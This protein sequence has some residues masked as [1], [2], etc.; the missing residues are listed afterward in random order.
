MEFNE[1]QL[2]KVNQE[3]PTSLF[4]PQGHRLLWLE[5][6]KKKTD[7][8]F[9]KIDRLKTEL[10]QPNLTDQKKNKLEKQIQTTQNKIE[11]LTQINQKEFFGSRFK[12]Y[13]F[14]KSRKGRK[15]YMDGLDLKSF[16]FIHKILGG[17]NIS[18][19]LAP[20]FMIEQ[21]LEKESYRKDTLLGNSKT[22]V[23]KQSDDVISGL[24][25]EFLSQ[26]TIPNK[27]SQSREAVHFFISDFHNLFDANQ[28]SAERMMSA[29]A[30]EILLTQFFAHYLKLAEDQMTSGDSISYRTKIKIYS[31]IGKI[32]NSA[33]QF[34]DFLMAAA[35]AVNPDKVNFYK[36]E[37]IEK[38]FAFLNYFDQIGQIIKQDLS[39]QEALLQI[40]QAEEKVK[41]FSI[42]REK[43]SKINFIPF[44]KSK[45][46]CYEMTRKY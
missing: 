40:N 15:A 42:T 17:R 22:P 45:G 7:P 41:S 44:K 20:Q 39:R 10:E 2:E 25:D 37:S 36:Y 13:L 33:M 6:L 12:R 21:T 30:L 3:G 5:R 27:S 28:T 29:A 23:Y 34:T 35:F 1:Q 38:F 19:S 9:L 43:N 46:R 18:W 4:H 24:V 32:Q 14:L 26:K 31:K 16:D 8:L 11:N